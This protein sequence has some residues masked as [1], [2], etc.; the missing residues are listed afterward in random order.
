M[1]ESRSLDEAHN[2]R[3]PLFQPV[4]RCDWYRFDPA[5]IHYWTDGGKSTRVCTVHSL[6]THDTF[7]P[8]AAYLP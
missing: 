6:A 8:A 1:L 3:P 5:T 4:S 7:Q 2:T